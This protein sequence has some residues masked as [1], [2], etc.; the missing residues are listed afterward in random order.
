[1]NNRSCRT[2][3]V[4]GAGGFVGRHVLHALVG[5]EEPPDR[6]V[7]LDKQERK[8]AYCDWVVCDMTDE[9]EVVHLIRRIRPDGVIHLAGVT[10]ASDLHSYFRSNVLGCANLLKA[11]VTCGQWPR[12]IVVGTAAQYDFSAGNGRP[13]T[14]RSPLGCAE[15]YGLSKN[16]QEKWALIYAQ[17]E[18]LPL[19]C[20]RIF[21]ILGPGQPPSLVPATFLR[22]LLQVRQSKRPAIRV[23]NTNTQRDFVDVRD[24]ARAIVK[25]LTCD[26]FAA[27]ECF[28]IASGGTVKVG[29]ILRA[30]LALAGQPNIPVIADSTRRKVADTRTA[31][32]DISKVKGRIDWQPEIHWRESIKDMWLQINHST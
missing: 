2:I 23:G 15:P 16:L 13:V 14:E 25:L 31:A 24:V 8:A 28:N 22:Q 27:G 29:Q 11:I 5:C 4:T 30:C 3:L 6:I 18:G 10:H 32:A 21:N 9:R 20:L 7:G 12:I 17:R 26:R 1:M 19:C